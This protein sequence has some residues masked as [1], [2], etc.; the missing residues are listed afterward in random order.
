M[1]KDGSTKHPVSEDRTQIFMSI[2]YMLADEYGIKDHTD[3]YHQVQLLGDSVARHVFENNHKVS[4][5]KKSYEDRKRFIAIFKTRYNET[6]DLEYRKKITPA[7]GKLIGQV[8]KELLKTGFRADDYLEWVFET[9]LP[10]NERFGVPTIKAVTGQY[11]VHNFLTANRELK[12]SKNRQEL[13]KKSGQDLIQR[14]RG[15][16][17]EG[18]SDE[19]KKKIKE[20]L[21]GYGEQRIML[22]QFRKVVENFEATYR[23][24]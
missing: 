5:Q 10:D 13:D 2:V 1:S 9:F 8:N 19:D 4:P 22:S 20:A 23:Q 21:S 3:V 17:R 24:K 6:Y 15:L 11:F 7:E 14:V 16:I 12:D 18:M